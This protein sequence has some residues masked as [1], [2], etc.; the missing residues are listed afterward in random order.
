MY[1]EKKIGNKLQGRGG[2]GCVDVQEHAWLSH[3]KKQIP[4][5]KQL[6]VNT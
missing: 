3:L 5:P 6:H 1:G 2:G 4:R